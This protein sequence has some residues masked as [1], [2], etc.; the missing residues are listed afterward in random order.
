MQTFS[1]ILIEFVKCVF[2]Q[3]IS[4]TTVEGTSSLDAALKAEPNEG[5]NTWTY[6]SSRVI[7]QVGRYENDRHVVALVVDTAGM[8]QDKTDLGNGTHTVTLHS[9]HNAG[10][11]L[12]NGLSPTPCLH[13]HAIKNDEIELLTFELLHMAS[14]YRMTERQE[15]VIIAGTRSRIDGLGESGGKV[16]PFIIT[17]RNQGSPVHTLVP[18]S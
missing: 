8:S 11:Q 6:L 10:Q 2:T 7:A 9:D 5:C 3:V 18:A 15:H 14:L 1:L 4:N 17:H 16:D 12:E 13:L